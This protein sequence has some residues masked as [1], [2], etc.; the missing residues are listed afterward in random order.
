MG[1]PGAEHDSPRE[2]LVR[3]NRCDT[4]EDD[5]ACAADARRPRPPGRRVENDAAV[6]NER[7]VELAQDPELVRS[8]LP[9]AGVADEAR[10]EEPVHPDSEART[11]VRG[12]R[13]ETIPVKEDAARATAPPV[14]EIAVDPREGRAAGQPP[15]H[16]RHGLAPGDE[17]VGEHGLQ[18]VEAARLR[19]LEHV[20]DD[21]L[22][23]DRVPL[24][25]VDDPWRERGG[26]CCRRKRG[27]CDD[28]EKDS[29]PQHPFTRETKSDLD[30]KGLL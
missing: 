4:R 10:A 8:E 15:L 27:R 30:Y 13:R 3:A 26:R 28:R 21:T 18:V 1:V 7:M 12:P 16:R 17:A 9:R 2:I 23:P 6:L 14:E 24:A 20:H 22:P 25:L 19:R 11:A 5:L 29:F